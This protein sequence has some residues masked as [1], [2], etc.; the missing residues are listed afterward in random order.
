MTQSLV[1]KWNHGVIEGKLFIHSH[2]Y[3]SLIVA[4]NI[5]NNKTKH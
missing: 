1:Q 2:H 5:N 3:L 4:E